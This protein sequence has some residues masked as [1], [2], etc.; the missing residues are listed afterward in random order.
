MGMFDYVKSERSLPDGFQGELQSKDFDC[1]MTLIKITAEGRLIIDRVIE[2]AEVPKA[3]RPYPNAP[4]GSLESICGSVR[5]VTNPV[6]LDYHGT[7]NFYGTDR[8]GNWHEYNAKFT[9]GNLV[10]IEQVTAS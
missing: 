10:E 4:D 3:E 8:I 9:D 2:W 5:F 6:D 7:F 1:D